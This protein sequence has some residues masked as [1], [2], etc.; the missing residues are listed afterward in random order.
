[1]ATSPPNER[2]IERIEN[3]ISLLSSEIREELRAGR[4][5][6]DAILAKMADHRVETARDIAAIKTQS[7][8]LAGLSS[9][10]GATLTSLVAHIYPNR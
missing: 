2:D 8:L 9:V 5:E 3:A 7:K 4:A 6:R 10:V 1:M